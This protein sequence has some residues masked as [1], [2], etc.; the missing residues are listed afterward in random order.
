MGKTVLIFD[1][2]VGGLSIYR[3]IRASFSGLEYIYAFDNGAFPYGELPQETLISRTCGIVGE[4][5]RKHHVDLVVIACNTAST[6]VLP[7]LRNQLTVPVV[8]VVPA[9][10]PAAAYSKKKSIGLLATP[11][12]VSR[13]YTQQLIDAFAWD[14]DVI[15]VG[16]T[17]LVQIGEEK[18]RGKKVNHEEIGQILSPFVG[19]VDALVLGCTHFPLLRKELS[20]VMGE[21]VALVD[22]GEAIARRV[23]SLLD[24]D[25]N[26]NPDSGKRPGLVFCTAPV[27]EEQALNVSLAELHLSKVKLLTHF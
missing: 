1:S 10:K 13:S 17:R 3:E 25:V 16:S 21:G 22:S 2:G 6:I 11:A 4:L 12:T 9:I 14:C 18:L 7:S 23:G 24:I 5:C 19:K 27:Y 8:G 26:K 15:K 20:R